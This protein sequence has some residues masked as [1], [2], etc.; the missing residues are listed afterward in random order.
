[1]ERGTGEGRT[2]RL[3]WD[4]G[5][6]T[7]WDS[8]KFL[9]YTRHQK[10]MERH[11]FGRCQQQG[12]KKH[13]H[14]PFALVNRKPTLLVPI[15]IFWRLRVWIPSSSALIDHHLLDAGFREQL[16]L[17]TNTWP[18]EW[19]P[20][21]EHEGN[22]EIPQNRFQP[23]TLWCINQVSTIHIV[24]SVFLYVCIIMCT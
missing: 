20:E 2:D 19:S 11:L 6:H 23:I 17:Y 12:R 13:T 10:K 18:Q 14:K 15:L 22:S 4:H 1:M 8:G 9:S 24:E 16:W 3:L 5:V 7:L 21:W